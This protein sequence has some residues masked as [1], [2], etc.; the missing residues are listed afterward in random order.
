MAWVLYTI[1]VWVLYTIVAWLL[2]TVTVWVLYSIVWL[3]EC[4]GVGEGRDEPD[5]ERTDTGGG[6]EDVGGG[7]GESG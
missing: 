1:V 5:A 2:Y 6:R 4:N 7:C 3:Q